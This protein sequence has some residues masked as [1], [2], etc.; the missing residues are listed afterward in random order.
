MYVTFLR[1]PTQRRHSGTTPFFKLSFVSTI[2]KKIKEDHGR[3][4]GGH[5]QNIKYPVQNAAIC[6]CTLTISSTLSRSQRLK[7]TVANERSMKAKLD[8]CNLKNATEMEVS[9]TAKDESSFIIVVVTEV[10]ENL[11]FLIN[12]QS[13]YRYSFVL[14][15]E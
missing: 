15:S 9:L 3:N 12:T 6:T 10:M 13:V 2:L 8:P 7:P 1:I 11:L 14:F 5:K 4:I